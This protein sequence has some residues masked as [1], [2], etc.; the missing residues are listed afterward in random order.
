MMEMAA[1]IIL[2]AML[3]IIAC[4]ICTPIIF[5]SVTVSKFC[6]IIG[7]ITLLVMSGFVNYL[8]CKNDKEND[9]K[10]K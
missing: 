4:C 8:M 2:L 10:Y 6:I 3:I 7:L 1:N 5:V 9:R